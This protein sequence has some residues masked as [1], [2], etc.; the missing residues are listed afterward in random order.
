MNIVFLA[1]FAGSPNHGMVLGHYYLAREWVKIG[2][3]VTIIAASFAHTRFV[4][5]EVAK[6]KICEEYI[7]GIRYIWIPCPVYDGSS[8]FGRVRNIISFVFKTWFFQL[9]LEKIDLVITSSHHPFAIFPARKIAQTWKTKLVFEV[10]DLW[11]LTLIEIGGMNRTHPFIRAMQ[12]AEDFAYRQADYVVSVLSNAKEYMTQHGMQE[13]K[14]LYVPNG[15]AVEN[16]QEQET[17]PAAHIQSI[18]EVRKRGGFLIGFA[19]RIVEAYCLDVLIDALK[20]INQLDIYFFFIGDGYRKEIIRMKCSEMG[21]ANQVFFLDSV[22]QCQVTDFLSRMDACYLGVHKKPMFRFGISP[23]KLNDYL[24]A[25]KP[26]IFVTDAADEAIEHSG[27]V[28]IC[29][30]GSSEE[31]KEAI[32]ALYSMPL[33]RRQ[34]MGEKGRKWVCRE[35]DYRILA[36]RFLEGV[37]CL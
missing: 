34:E 25:A 14:F 23:T 28:I 29:R 1:H 30:S 32:L 8:R 36:K 17:L 15:A 11:P 10:R 16:L 5:P 18:E 37:G 13:N 20:L 19:G 35:R 26:V 33:S 7:D 2:H 6:R 27:A 22:A 3:N 12:W 31:I 21:L 4:Q 24:L 9:P